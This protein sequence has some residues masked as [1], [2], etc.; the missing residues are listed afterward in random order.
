MENRCEIFLCVNTQEYDV[1][2][3]GYG[4]V[5]MCPPCLA[6]KIENPDDGHGKTIT[7]RSVHRLDSN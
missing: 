2:V 7:I 4:S 6:R 1:H 5:K 3:I